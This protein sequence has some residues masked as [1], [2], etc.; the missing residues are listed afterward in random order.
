MSW[1]DN[2]FIIIVSVVNFFSMF[3]YSLCLEESV[4][5]SPGGY[6]NSGNWCLLHR[7]CYISCTAIFTY[8]SGS[9]FGSWHHDINKAKAARQ[10]NIC[11]KMRTWYPRMKK[12]EFGIPFAPPFNFLERKGGMVFLSPIISAS[13]LFCGGDFYRAWIFSYLH[14][15]TITNTTT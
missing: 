11:N 10:A 6:G 15:I 13:F 14:S 9:F 4:N 7:K 5:R 8:H 3:L 12:G 2:D 1:K